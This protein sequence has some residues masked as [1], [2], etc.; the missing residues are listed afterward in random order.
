MP[1]RIPVSGASTPSSAPSNLTPSRGPSVWDRPA[2][3]L[4]WKDIDVEHW[5][6]ITAGVALAA[7]GLSRRSR[8]GALLALAGG[9]LVARAL[10]GSRDVTVLRT[11]L[12][13]WRGRARVNAVDDAIEESFPASDPPSWTAGTTAARW[14]GALVGRPDC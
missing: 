14:P 7:A 6:E 11:R 5:L 1:E 4:S 12:Q 13:S 8:G 2:A 9:T 10:L 3:G